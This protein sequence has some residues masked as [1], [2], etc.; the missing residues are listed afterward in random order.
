VTIPSQDQPSRPRLTR[1]QAK[2][3]TRES[4]LEAAA[5]VFGNKGFAGASV[6]EIADQAGYSIGALYSNF[7]GK[8]ELFLE[9]MASR[10]HDRVADTTQ[11]LQDAHASAGMPWQALGQQMADEA[12]KDLEVAALQAEFW[13]YAV[14]HPEVMKTFAARVRRRR[15]PLEQLIA[16]ELKRDGGYR[17]DLAGRL[18]IVLSALF[19]GL[20]RQRRIDPDNVPADLYSDALRWLITG[21]RSTEQ[22]DKA[23]HDD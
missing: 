2:A 8:E 18:A 19:Q 13:L 23:G 11:M 7:A 10:A 4:L 20:V 21:M 1:A 22:Q 15:E 3:R 5:T 9:L 16:S 12:D 14:R 6:E 17:D